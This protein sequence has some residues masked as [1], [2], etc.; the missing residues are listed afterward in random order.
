[1]SSPYWNRFVR[2][3]LSK[4]VHV[5]FAATFTAQAKAGRKTKGLKAAKQIKWKLQVKQQQPIK[6]LKIYIFLHTL[7]LS[8]VRILDIHSPG[9]SSSVQLLTNIN[10]S[11]QPTQAIKALGRLAV[12]RR[13]W[14]HSLHTAADHVHMPSRINAG[15][16]ETGSNSLHTK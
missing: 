2:L 8:S 9:T 1:M 12:V 16:K 14:P 3:S 13:Q 15:L 5:E 11:N 7:T 4:A 6:P 10:P